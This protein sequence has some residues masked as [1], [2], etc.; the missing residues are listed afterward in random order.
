MDQFDFPMINNTRLTRDQRFAVVLN[1]FD[2]RQASADITL[3]YF[4]GK[5]T[6]LRGKAVLRRGPRPP[7][8]RKRKNRP[9]GSQ[10]PRNP[11]T[12]L[13]EGGYCLASEMS[14]PEKGPPHVPI[15][16]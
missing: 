14:P 1:N 5:Y 15:P 7:P 10:V 16:V 3:A 6:G 4:P 9:R 2:S 12:A 13:P 11:Q 8:R